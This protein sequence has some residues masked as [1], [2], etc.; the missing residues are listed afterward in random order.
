[1]ILIIVLVASRSADCLTALQLGSLVAVVPAVVV[2]VAHHVLRDAVSVGASELA[3]AA[4]L[5]V[6]LWKRNNMRSREHFGPERRNEPTAGKR[7]IGS[8][9]AILVEIAHPRLRDALP[10][11]ALE[12]VGG[13]RAARCRDTNPT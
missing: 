1:M 4:S 9:N 5:H 7:F 10:I 13:A 11:V 8:I 6:I 2:A 12:L 3:D